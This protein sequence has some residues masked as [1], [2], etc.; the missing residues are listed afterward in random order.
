MQSIVGAIARQS[1]PQRSQ[2]LIRFSLPHLQIASQIANILM[3]CDL[4]KHAK[5]MAL[6]KVHLGEERSPKTMGAHPSQ[7][8]VITALSQR[9]IH[10][11]GRDMSI[12]AAWK[13][14]SRFR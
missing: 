8:Q 10:S 13:Q 1:V 5:T 3:L 14:I 4:L 9:F 11:L 6:F 12:K 7:A 2:G